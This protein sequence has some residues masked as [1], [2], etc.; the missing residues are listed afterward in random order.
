MHVPN[1]YFKLLPLAAIF[2]LFSTTAF[3][4]DW[5]SGYSK[6]A[7]EAGVCQVGDQ[8]RLVSFGARDQW[9]VKPQKGVVTCDK[10]TFGSDPLPNK[11]KKCALGPLVTTTPPPGG[12]N[13]GDASNEAAPATGWAGYGK[14]TTGG[15]GAGATSIYTVSSAWQ[16]QEALKRSG[17]QPRIIKVYG[18]IDMASADNGGKFKSAS[19][20][21]AR[22]AIVLPSN[23][24]LIGLG[25]SAQIRNGRIVIKNVENVI[26]R[27]LQ[28]VNPCDIAPVW[29]PN[30]GS[31]GNWNS[32]YDGLV[33]EGARH[34]WIDHNSFTDFPDTDD[35]APVEKGKI[36]QCHDG[37]LDV[38]KAAD[39][40]TV[41]NNLFELHSKN[42]LVGSSDSASEDE[43]HLTVT[44]NNNYFRNVSERSPRVR[45]GKVHLYNNYYEGTKG[46]GIYPHKYSIGVGYKAKILSQN[47]VFDVAGAAACKD[48]II[49]PGSASKTGA[50][51]DSGSLLN[52][53]LLSVGPGKDCAFNSA[54]GWQVPYAVQ[55]LPAS[56]V[57]D[58]VKRNA[59]AGK[60]QVR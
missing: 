28:I 47:N 20:Q 14:G 60:L 57:R 29:D 45:F 36:K 31:S 17:I 55:P 4:K 9:V 16:L 22:N 46:K 11:I 38:K 7:D 58:S 23:T 25:E 5:P 59:G 40:I 13:T 6:C 19:D 41:S 35:R 53:S 37:A 39:Y 30:D 8:P 12:G 50:M 24:T 33:V 42:N 21:A 44:F 43:G 49:N 18:N 48:V 27:N 10:A 34:V 1:A 52:G 54:I 51:A 32:E 56:S 15:R 3:A 26:V 2:A